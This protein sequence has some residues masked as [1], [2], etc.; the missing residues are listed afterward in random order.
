M[1][2][3]FSHGFAIIGSESSQLCNA[4]FLSINNSYVKAIKKTGRKGKYA[5]KFIDYA[6]YQLF[7]YDDIKINGYK[8]YSQVGYFDHK[9]S[10][11]SVKHVYQFLT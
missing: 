5:L 6:S 1:I 11:L 3:K 9:F 7:A 8:E 2:N 10:L 4:I